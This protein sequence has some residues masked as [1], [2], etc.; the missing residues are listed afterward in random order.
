MSAFSSSALIC[1]STSYRA[2]NAAHDAV[3]DFFNSIRQKWSS[4]TNPSYVIWKRT[5]AIQWV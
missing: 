5:S 2:E 3:G 4:P 1:C